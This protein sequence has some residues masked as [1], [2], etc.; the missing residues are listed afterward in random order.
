MMAGSV[1]KA[2]PEEL[3][4]LPLGGA[5]EI[6]MNLNLYHYGGK[7]LMVDLG[8]TFGDETTPGID[9]IMPDPSFIEERRRDLLGLVV[10]HGHEDHIGAIPYLWERLRCPIHATPFTASLVR[11]KLTDAGLLGQV[12]LIEVPI[13]GN[14][15]LGPFEIELIGL[16]HSIPEPNGIVLRCGAGTILHTG[17][18]KFDPEPQIGAVTDNAALE[19]VAEEGVL[20]M[21][22]D[23][24]NVD[25][26]GSTGSE[27]ELLK[28]FTELFGS[29]RNRIV[30]TCFASNVARL[31]S[32][33]VAAR[34]NGRNAALVGRSLWRMY[35][36]ARE[37]GYLLDIPE[38]LSEEDVGYLPRDKV[39][40]LCTGSQGESRAAMARI[41]AEYSLA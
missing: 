34:R 41:A 10:T 4:F 29:L 17:D 26:P 15:I 25:V 37:N 24:T 2:D 8:I 6:G 27:A 31:H 35:D 18:W 30:V 28:T 5:D 32:I 19:A 16:T 36:S 11:R 38:F 1:F 9:V 39:V 3:L 12:D 40:M 22:G 33:A 21:I 20:A 7:W 23:S 13:S 14:F